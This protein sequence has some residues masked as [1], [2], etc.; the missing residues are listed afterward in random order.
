MYKDPI[1]GMEVSEQDNKY[2]VHLDHD[3]Y[4]FCSGHCKEAF[5]IETG[6]K[7]EKKGVIRRFLDRLAAENN[8]TY[9]NQKPKCH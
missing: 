5:E 4:Y 2:Q 9:G 1:C 6:L 7:H 3:T 8:K